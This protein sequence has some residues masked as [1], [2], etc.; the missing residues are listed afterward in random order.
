MP[1]VYVA[2]AERTSPRRTAMAQMTLPMDL[3]RRAAALGVAAAVALGS[4]SVAL[5][6]LN[7]NG[8]QDAYAEMMRAMEAQR[9]GATW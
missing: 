2:W 6:G 4:P 1:S 7:K 3:A 8:N 5:A 9:W